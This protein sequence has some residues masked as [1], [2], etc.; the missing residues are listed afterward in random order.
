MAGKK[1]K[2]SRIAKFIRSAQT[3]MKVMG[4]IVVPGETFIG[5]YE[6]INGLPGMRFLSW[7]TIEPDPVLETLNSVKVVDISTE[8]EEFDKDPV[9]KTSEPFFDPNV[10]EELLNMNGRQW[11]TLK[12]KDLKRIMDDANVDYSKVKDDRMELYKFLKT[13]LEQYTEVT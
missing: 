5:P 2:D 1:S 3:P 10:L 6:L 7:N 11:M 12:K 9:D 13:V 4:R 8:E